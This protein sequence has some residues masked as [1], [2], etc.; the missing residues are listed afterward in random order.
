MTDSGQLDFLDLIS[1]LSFIIAVENLNEN[2][3]QS[4]KQELLEE[5]NNKASLLLNEI[6]RHL[7]EQ[8]N[9]LSAIEQ[10]TKEIKDVLY[11]DFQ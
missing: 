10:T 2:V 6:H 4:D 7:Q 5:F 8:D 9:R 3:T 11:R 1:I